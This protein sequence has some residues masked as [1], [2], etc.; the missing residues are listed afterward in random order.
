MELLEGKAKNVRHTMSVS[1]SSGTRTS[2]I[3][4]FVVS[5]RQVTLSVTNVPPVINEGDE[6]ILAGITEKGVFLAA[7]YKN[8]TLGVEGYDGWMSSAVGALW[9]A[10]FGG[11][12]S[13][14]GITNLVP[15]L[16]K[17]R[18]AYS[19]PLSGE[20]LLFG[21][22]AAIGLLCIGVSLKILGVTVLQKRCIE[23]VATS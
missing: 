5:N 3:A 14:I 19:A 7:A 2:H 13:I 12:F 21:A 17:V 18:D 20:L 10:G 23:A 4:Q 16:G 8:R 9:F 11:V 15:S 22:F 6:L 1:G